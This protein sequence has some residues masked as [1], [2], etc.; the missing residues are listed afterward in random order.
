MPSHISGR[1]VTAARHHGI[2]HN[3]SLFITFIDEWDD[4]KE[5]ALRCKVNL[6]ALNPG[7]GIPDGTP[8]AERVASFQ[9]C[10]T[11]ARHHGIHHFSSLFITFIDEWDDE[12][13]SPLR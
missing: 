5:S 3:S 7:P 13:E 10:V 8:T 1:S 4:E 9:R 11:A 6:I 2:H 12:K